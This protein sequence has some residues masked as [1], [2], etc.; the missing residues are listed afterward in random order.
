LIEAPAPPPEEKVVERR[1]E[2]IREIPAEVPRSVR[3]WDMMSMHK[4]EKRSP[5]P[6]AKS[7]KSRAH[8]PAKSHKSRARSLSSASTQR[9]EIIRGGEKEESATV[10]GG[11]FALMEPAHTHRRDE[12]SIRAEIRALE[13]EKKALKLEREMEKER[14]KAD[15]YRE[16]EFEV[17]RDVVK[18]EKDRKGRLSLVRTAD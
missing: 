7:R 8:S 10:H 15:R 12:R 17:V 1:T 6:S 16:T 13:A 5:S 18:I 2:I 9:V 4:S 14:S 3:E 11:A